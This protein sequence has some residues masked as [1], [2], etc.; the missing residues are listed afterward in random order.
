MRFALSPPDGKVRSWNNGTTLPTVLLVAFLCTILALLLKP[1]VS[2]RWNPSVTRQARSRGVTEESIFKLTCM[3][4]VAFLINIFLGP[5]AL[6]VAF[7][8]L[9]GKSGTS[10]EPFTNDEQLMTDKWIDWHNHG[11]LVGEIF[12]GYILFMSVM[13]MISWDPWGLD[14]LA[15]HILFFAAGC[16]LAGT[17]TFPK[18]AAW[19]IGMECSSPPLLIYLIAR[20]IDGWDSLATITSQVFGYS[21]LFFRCILYTYGF[22]DCAISLM[23][24]PDLMPLPVGLGVVVLVMFGAGWVLQLWWFVGIYKKSK[25]KQTHDTA[26]IDDPVLIDEADRSESPQ[27]TTAYA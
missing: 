12:T 8:Y 15:H 16:L 25:R 4:T 14:T 26:P 3:N 27:I 1:I 20:Q 21:F 5:Y 22:W 6:V 18:L 2:R 9:G 13:L 10:H 24:N 11:A 19:A 23:I 17:S 7:G